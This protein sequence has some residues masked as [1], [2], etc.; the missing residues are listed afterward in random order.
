[1]YT[2]TKQL[3]Q[4]SHNT[5]N[6]RHQQEDTNMLHYKFKIAMKQKYIITNAIISISGIRGNNNNNTSNICLC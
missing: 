2:F 4:I 5:F 6:D 3:H 1:M